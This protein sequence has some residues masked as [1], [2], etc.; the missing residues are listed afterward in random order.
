MVMCS[1]NASAIIQLHTTTTPAATQPAL[2]T[3]VVRPVDKCK[4]GKQHWE[5]HPGHLVHTFANGLPVLATYLTRVTQ[6][7]ISHGRESVSAAAT[8][9]ERAQKCTNVLQQ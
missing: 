2:P 9:R 7:L 6:H 1:R 8:V 4:G 3:Q 5:H